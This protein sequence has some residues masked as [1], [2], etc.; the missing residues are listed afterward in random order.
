M[1]G[2]LNETAG[3]CHLSLSFR[4][5]CD[6]DVCSNVRNPRWCRPVLEK[7]PLQD[8]GMR[9]KVVLDSVQNN[10][11]IFVHQ[12]NAHGDASGKPF[13]QKKQAAQ[14]ASHYK[15]DNIL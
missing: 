7:S 9:R 11:Y 4:L 13:K 3:G 1:K 6:G 14:S 2:M 10:L 12:F 5:M 15:K 8:W